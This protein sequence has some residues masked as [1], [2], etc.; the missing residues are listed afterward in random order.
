MTALVVRRE[1]DVRRLG[2]RSAK[3][4]LIA[5]RNEQVVA[6][7]LD[8][9]LQDASKLGSPTAGCRTAWFRGNGPEEGQEMSSST[10]EGLPAFWETYGAR[11]Q[12]PERRGGL[13]EGAPVRAEGSR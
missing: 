8:D 1:P 11:P 6:A 4:D 2:R 13:G 9:R 10:R 3:T 7:S 12:C 5:A